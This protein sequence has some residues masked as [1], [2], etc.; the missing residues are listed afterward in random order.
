MSDAIPLGKREDLHLEFKSAD[1]LKDPEKLARE[2]VAMLNADG[3]E[4]WVG[5]GEEEERAVL[6][7]SV[8]DAE[9]ES[10]RLHD[11]LVDVIE[12]P[13][14]AQEVRVNIRESDEGKKLLCIETMPSSDRKP[15]AFLR[16]GGRFYVTRV[17]ARIRPMT[18][19]EIFSKQPEGLDAGVERAESTILAARNEVLASGRQVFWLRFEPG[20]E[21]SRDIQAPGLEQVLQDPRATDNRPSGWNF[22]QFETRPR[23]QQNVLVA[24]DEDEYRKVEV[25]R[26]GGLVFTA[27]LESLFWK[28]EENEI[29]PPILLEYV[30]SAFRMARAVYGMDALRSEDPVV[31]DLALAGAGGWKLRAGTP[32]WAGFSR[33][34][35]VLPSSDVVL[36]QPLTF[37]IGE[38]AEP[39]RC[40]RRLIEL[41]YEA[42]GIRREGIPN[43]FDSESGRLV[44]PE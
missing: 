27:L 9:R 3:G 10:R 11:Y 26:D 36:T 29:W 15:Y 7:E 32:G 38:I 30:V 8:P 16:K 20:V 19:D 21:I 14:D 43:L 37:R 35:A 33:G 6:V 4:V 22:A 12:P 40:A 17:G 41:V 31:V 23:I 39:D 5:L 1:S 18:R 34:R 2:I 44:L 25:R 28:G 42:F 13:P 24:A